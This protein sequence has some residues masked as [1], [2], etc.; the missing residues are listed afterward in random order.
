ML[1]D[2]LAADQRSRERISQALADTLFVEAGAG[3]GKTRALVDRYVALV[4]S[5][6]RVDELVAITFT[7]KAAAEL[8]DRI[9]AELERRS[10]G[11]PDDDRSRTALR[12]LDRAQIGTIHAFCAAVLR[13]FAAE[14]GIDP[15]FGIHDE[16]AAER[17]FEARWLTHLDGLADD[18]KA[19]GAFKRI[20]E[21]GLSIRDLQRLAH[22]LW[23]NPSLALR[24]EAS[25]LEAEPVEWPDLAVLHEELAGLGVDSVPEDDRLGK[26]IRELQRMVAE[27][28]A[29]PSDERHVRL[30]A[31][32]SRL[33]QKLGTTGQRGNWRT[34]PIA[35]AR[36][37]GEQI[38]ATL[39]Q[40][41][42]ALRSEALGAFLPYVVTFANDD[43][44]DRVRSG[45]LIFE[46]LI[47]RVDQ[48][49][50]GSPAARRRLRER[51]AAMLIDE[52]QDTDP[53]QTRIALAFARDPDTEQLDHGRLFLVGDP[54]QSIYR[55]RRADMAVYAQTRE[56]L[57]AAGAGEERLSLN[58]RSQPAIL[59]FVNAV[60]AGIIGAGSQAWVQPAY[61]PVHAARVL[62]PGE[63]SVGLLG[64]SRQGKASEVRRFEAQQI[65]AYCRAVLDQ[66][67]QVSDRSEPE[68][69]RPA[70]FRD[71]AILVPTRAILAPLERALSDA[72]VPYRI[73]GG[74]LVYA[75]QEVRDLINCLSA[76]DD[77]SDEI[78][79]IGALR[80][81][82]Y[83]CSD[84][85]LAE[86][87][88]QGRTFNYL[89]RR[90]EQASGR[91]AAALMHLREFHELRSHVRIAALVE[92]FI[93][94][95]RLVEVGLFTTGSRDPFRRARFI[96][97]QARL[98][99]AEAPESL[100][101]FVDWLERRAN[102]A[103]Y[104][105]E[106]AALDDDED[107]VRIMTIHAA[108][109]LEFPIVFLAGLGVS[110]S[111]QM[112]PYLVDRHSDAIAVAS[113]SETRGNKRTLGAY[114]VVSAQE[115]LH[116][117]AE[118]VRVLYV[119]ATRARDHL[120]MSLYHQERAS[121]TY[122]QTLIAG[123][124]PMY[125]PI[126]PELPPVTGAR[127]GP[128]AELDVDVV[129]EAEEEFIARREDLVTASRGRRIESATSLGRLNSEEAE[130]ER[131]DE[132][133]PWAR[134]R[135]GTKRGRA[136][137]AALQV[138]PWEAADDVI[139]ALA[140][141]QC[142]AEAIPDQT[143][144]VASL[145][146]RG[147]ST[148]VAGRARAA[149]RALREVPFAFVRNG[150]TLEGFIDLVIEG[151]TG[152]LEIV[153]WKTDAIPRDA[154]PRR[155]ERYRLQAG[156]YVLGLEA[157]TGRT[158]DRVTYV[159]VAA[160]EEA[161]PGEPAALA[162]AA[163]ETIDRLMSA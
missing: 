156:L 134:G 36:D 74:S 16:V 148:E 20:R 14:H 73:E 64:G 72:G 77:P 79:I 145:L 110:R 61:Q 52:F 42:T 113:G 157:V 51:Y 63:P 8:R 158:V 146:R 69:M 39:A 95:R 107:A 141:A 133:E 19:R 38:G 35:Q 11:A 111:N 138:L 22:D 91:V 2:H 101:S 108:K 13:S 83:A 125:A 48:V 32:S 24:L 123:L 135:A 30:A 115:Q 103:I 70:T 154:I 121:A 160:G 127:T 56:E 161:S 26:R 76:I 124:A 82:A 75:T 4:M 58:R 94:G 7:E 68:T 34:V 162:A 143:E 81:P 62:S 53:L 5:G 71:V 31:L 149:K 132:S 15:T 21:L 100:R 37:L 23:A 17:R 12:E 153:D 33:K 147:L 151:P 98:F 93:A 89:D 106:G 27:L 104:D 159:F 90:N 144:A 152:G 1:D 140:R 59:E 120:V 117:A 18:A 137:H 57:G 155:L 122:A 54:K 46:D 150:V 116:D 92:R 40:T 3:T 105:Y 80:S 85:E 49:L 114:D 10:A 97:E 66:G 28:R 60:F 45:E 41:L 99:E 131:D 50:S 25:P 102:E 130:E 88:L 112:P 44:R 126:L 119:G 6:R 55:F 67:W 29:S 163:S 65:A 78:A 118:R 84:V 129:R 43:A 139:E 136:V 9:R 142:V 86:H 128:F 109:G 96:I 47:V 87:R